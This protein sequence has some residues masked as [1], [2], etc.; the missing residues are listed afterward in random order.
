M[1]SN[2]Q[3]TTNPNAIPITTPTMFPNTPNELPTMT[4][5]TILT[6][7]PIKNEPTI[8]TKTQRHSKVIP[9]MLPT[10]P[11]TTLVRILNLSQEMK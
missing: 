6:T 9:K 11:I 10:T 4:P 5:M 7:P 2:E 1:I 3:T 8:P